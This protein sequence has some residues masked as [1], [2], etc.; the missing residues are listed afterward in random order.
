MFSNDVCRD[1]FWIQR[2]A[3][4]SQHSMILCVRLE[5]LIGQNC[6]CHNDETIVREW[7]WEGIGKA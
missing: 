5:S 6:L 3:E 1:K 7:E 4:H 2:Q